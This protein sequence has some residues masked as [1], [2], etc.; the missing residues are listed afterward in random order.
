ML[1]QTVTTIPDAIV[2]GARQYPDKL[3]KVH[4]AIRP[5]TTTRADLYAESRRLAAG[6]IG[7]GVRPGDVVALQLPNWRECLAA[8]AG[9]W[10]AGAVVLPI[11]P[12][13]GPAEVAF[14][15]RQSGARALIL[16]REIRN[17]DAAGTLR[18]VAELPGLEHRI[19]VGDPL[20]GTTPYTDLAATPPATSRRRR[21]TRAGARCW[22]T[23]RAPPP[24]PRACSTATPACS[25]RSAPW[26]R[27]GAA[28]AI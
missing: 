22:C 20:P 14:I 24:N 26:T 18:A 28:A 11:V 17:R 25:A 23:P 5:D 21:R 13:Y 4:S 9:I 2:E 27:C 10:L 1:T 6:L 3:V 7:L 8:H 19:L 12:S 15:A 16:A